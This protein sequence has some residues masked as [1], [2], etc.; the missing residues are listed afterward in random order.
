MKNLALLAVVFC[1][2]ALAS[3]HAQ[4]ADAAE[5]SPIASPDETTLLKTLKP[6]H[7]RLLIA[8]DTW[9]QLKARRAHD[10]ELDAFLTRQQAEARALL[11]AP[12]VAYKKIGRR[13]LDVSRTVLRRVLLLSMQYKLTG[14]KQFLER[15][16]SEMLNAASYDD[17][18]PSHFLDTAEMTAALAIGTDW[19]YDDLDAEARTIIKDAIHEKGLQAGLKNTGWV[20]ATNNWNSV[21][22]AGMVLGALA[23][24]D[25]E[26]QLAAHYVTQAIEFNPRVLKSYAPDGIYPEGPGYWAY[27]T[28]FQVMLVSALQSALGEGWGLGQAPGFLPSVEALFH[29]AGPSGTFYNYSDGGERTSLEGTTYWFAQQLNQPALARLE[30]ASMRKYLESKP[31]PDSQ[32]E[33]TLPLAALWWPTKTARSLDLPLNWMGDGENPIATFRGSWDEPAAMW[34]ALKGGKASNSH[35]HMDAGSFVFES[36]GVRWARDLGAQSYDS[37]ESKGIGLWDS[38]QDGDRW[39]VFRIGPFSHN[40]LTING[41]LHKF[42]GDARL[43]KFSAGPNAGVVVDLSPVFAG[44]ATRVTRGFLF[45][46]G[47]DATIRDEVEGLKA[48]DKVRFALVTGAQIE[49]SD[50]GKTAT[51]KQGDKTLSAKLSDAVGG[52]WEIASAQGPQSYDVENKGMQLLVATFSAPVSGQMSWAVTF[53]PGS[54]EVAGANPLADKAIAD[55]PLPAVKKREE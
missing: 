37:L 55:W 9:T 15:A 26:P 1:A 35:G 46:T 34:L 6:T 2:L 40:T 33:R 10:A 12:P 5:K 30:S 48:G 39:K 22:N 7:P 31:R 25:D 43:T 51:L 8:D 32:G 45:R 42:D 17:W 28:T 49:V 16:Q 29:L 20:G 4:S 41:Q 44:Q 3:V 54:A 14:D 23:I 18:N 13:L 53:T 52:K 38:K 21:C 50:D 24:A 19:L 27:G 36:D 11:T 47:Q